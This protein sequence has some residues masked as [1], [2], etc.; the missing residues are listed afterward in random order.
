[1]SAVDELVAE[2]INPRGCKAR[3]VTDPEAVQFIQ[4]VTEAKQSGKAPNIARASDILKEEWSIDI[5]S[6][7]LREHARGKC[8]CRK[9]M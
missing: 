4:R 9:R 1:M 5:P 2:V 6:R 3:H 7:Q 8:G